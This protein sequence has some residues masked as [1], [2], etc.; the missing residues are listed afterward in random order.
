MGIY[1]NTATHRAVDT[2]FRDHPI[3]HYKRGQVLILPGET[4]EYA[5]Y[6][7]RGR[8]KVYD[9]SH[10]GDEITVDVFKEPA[11]FPLSL[12]LNRSST[13]YIYEADSDIEIRQAPADAALTFLT[14]NSDAVLD[15]M[16][17]LYDTL[18]DVI[19]RMVHLVAYS[20]KNRIIHELIV[21]CRHIGE[22]QPDGGYSLAMTEKDLGAK[23]GLSRE[24]V[25]REMRGLKE[26]GLLTIHHKHIFVADLV[27]LE[28][29]E[30]QHR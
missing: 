21:M 22:P 28:A 5:Y 8:M 25:S 6:L 12:I 2:F 13:R 1:M 20:A 24:T 4:A 16:S 14:S 10:R 19:D 23:I 17:R 18:D 7:V 15:L 11:I 29:Y 9:I 27:H 3:K 26:R 30:R